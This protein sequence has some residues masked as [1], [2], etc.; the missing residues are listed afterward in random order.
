VKVRTVEETFIHTHFATDGERL[1][2]ESARGIE[3]GMCE[4]LRERGI[5]FGVHL[6]RGERDAGIVVVLECR[7]LAEDLKQ[8]RK[9][10]AGMLEP[11]PRR[12]PITEVRI[13]DAPGG[14]TPRDRAGERE[15]GRPDRAPP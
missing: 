5:V 9:R 7:P 11:I 15:R 4:F 14:A 2:A 6:E 13:A 1:T 12:P 3:R 10:L 8:I